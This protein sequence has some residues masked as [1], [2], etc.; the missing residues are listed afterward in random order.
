MYQAVVINCVHKQLCSEIIAGRNR[1][2]S[3]LRASR[4]RRSD[5]DG[6][7]G[8]IVIINRPISPSMYEAKARAK[9][10]SPY[11]L[12]PLTPLGGAPP[13]PESPLLSAVDGADGNFFVFSETVPTGTFL[14]FPTA[15][16]APSEAFLCFPT[17]PA[18]PSET[19]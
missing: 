12:L 5:G 4:T 18:A 8:S 7:E 16:A 19:F 14:C 2:K 3:G 1:P 17:A 15:P 10:A 9:E 11:C 6:Q 13:P